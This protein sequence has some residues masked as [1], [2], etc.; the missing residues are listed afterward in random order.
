M[1]FLYLNYCYVRFFYDIC[2]IF[3]VKA[4]ILV[5]LMFSL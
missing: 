5:F 2:K 3:A 4:E 1:N